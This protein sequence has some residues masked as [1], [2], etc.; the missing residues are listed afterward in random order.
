MKDL[1]IEYRDGRLVELRIDGVLVDGVKTL[2]L[3]HVAGESMPELTVRMGMRGSETLIPPDIDR[4]T[5]KSAAKRFTEDAV[6]MAL[7][8]SQDITK[9]VQA[10][11]TKR[12]TEEVRPGG[13]LHRSK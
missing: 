13:I 2:S 12:L 11:I 5:F 1:I 8:P 10:T 3:S 9:S 6:V 7:T 4:K